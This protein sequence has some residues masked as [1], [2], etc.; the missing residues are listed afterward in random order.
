M[1]FLV[2]VRGVISEPQRNLEAPR[3]SVGLDATGSGDDLESEE[4]PC[5]SFDE[6]SAWQGKERFHVTS[7]RRAYPVF[8]P[9]LDRL[10]PKG[11]R[12]VCPMQVPVGSIAEFAFVPL[13]PY[14]ANVAITVGDLARVVIGDGDRQLLT[15]QRDV[16]LPDW[17]PAWRRVKSESGKKRLQLGRGIALNTEVY[18]VIGT[19]QVSG[20]RNLDLEVTV[21]GFED[22]GST[23]GRAK[24]WLRETYAIPTPSD[25]P[26]EKILYGV[27][28]LDPD[29]EGV[30][31]SLNSFRVR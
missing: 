23:D 11:G 18:V 17:P 16:A 7:N 27:E 12:L 19:S 13:H 1:L 4:N 2:L 29:S 10:Y 25:H 24:T 15:V 9:V 30:S 8:E 26:L 3:V 5:R 28:I 21:Y 31:A 14:K 22:D 20:S 6:H